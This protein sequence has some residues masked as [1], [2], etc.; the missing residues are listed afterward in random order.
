MR[1]MNRFSRLLL[2]FVCASSALAA[3]PSGDNSPLDQYIVMFK[4]SA[5]GQ[6]PFTDDD[7]TRLGGKIE[8]RYYNRVVVRIP[9]PAVEQ[10]K[11][12]GRVKYIQKTVT[13]DQ[14]VVLPRGAAAAQAL[15]PTTAELR[16]GVPTTNTTPPV[17]SSGTYL[18]DGAGNIYATQGSAYTSTY[19][20]DGRSRITSADMHT[21][22]AAT[23]EQYAY[24][25]YGNLLSVKVDAADPLLFGVDPVTNRAGQGPCDQMGNCAGTGTSIASFDPFGLAVDHW[26][27]STSGWYLYKASDERIGVNYGGSYTW[28]VRDFDGKVVRQYAS[29]PGDYDSPW[30]WLQDNVYRDGQL[31]A[32]A[33][34]DEEG[35][36]RD[37]HLDHLGSA[38]LVTGANGQSIAEHD[39]TPFGIE[40]TSMTQ[41]VRAGFD[42]EDPMKFTGHERDYGY[43]T[44]SEN[45]AYLDYMHA[46]YYKP[47]MGRFLSVDPEIAV[48]RNMHQPQGWNR[49]AYGLNNPML[50]HDP[51]GRKDTV[52][53]ISMLDAKHTPDIAAIESSSAGNAIRRARNRGW[54]RSHSRLSKDLGK[55]IGQQRHRRR[56]SSLWWKAE[57]CTWHDDGWRRTCRPEDRFHR[58]RSRQ[59]C[60]RRQCANVGHRGLQLGEVRRH[61]E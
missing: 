52:V 39:F 54:T 53:F 9:A 58:E 17:W 50:R 30:V 48:R 56:P 3:G 33:R 15:M 34:M 21:A 43:P 12:H 8:F 24:D 10:L 20:Y 22:N 36:V 27:G 61:C 1:V 45:R 6:P 28:S 60:N 41:E 18:Y 23:T 7:V 13:G 35:G 51:D 55:K 26:S 31:L 40:L 11:K 57:E 37:Y 2:L 5:P 59:G 19:T 32:S 16:N 42:R 47:A 29:D 38:R 49:Y 14:P 25:E 44:Y 4:E 46:R